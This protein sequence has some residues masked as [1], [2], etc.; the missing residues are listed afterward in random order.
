M[1]DSVAMERKK[2][3]TGLLGLG[4]WHAAKHAFVPHMEIRR[5]LRTQSVG[6][7]DICM[8]PPQRVAVDWPAR[9]SKVCRRRWFTRRQDAGEHKINTRHNQRGRR[10][11][12]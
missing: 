11:M 3:E 10:V 12:F 5:G 6:A 4:N 8:L 1:G 2:K 9:V 7:S